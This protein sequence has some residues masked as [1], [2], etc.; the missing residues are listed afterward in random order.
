MGTHAPV[1][2]SPGSWSEIAAL[3]VG[4]PLCGRASGAVLA[5]AV[6]LFIPLELPDRLGQCRV[7]NVCQTTGALASGNSRLDRA[8]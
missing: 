3:P 1:P 6:E 8:I 7:T 5:L 4:R 2:G